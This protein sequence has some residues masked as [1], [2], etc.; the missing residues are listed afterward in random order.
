M[1]R[2][3]ESQDD[4]DCFEESRIAGKDQS[5]QFIKAK[6]SNPNAFLSFSE[7]MPSVDKFELVENSSATTSKAEPAPTMKVD[8]TAL[9]VTLPGDTPAKE[10]IGGSFQSFSEGMPSID[11]FA[12]TGFR[13]DELC[14]SITE[15]LTSSNFPLADKFDQTDP[16]KLAEC[17]GLRTI[18][19]VI[20]R[21]FSVP[22]FDQ[23]KIR[24]GRR[25]LEREYCFETNI[26]SIDTTHGSLQQILDFVHQ[27]YHST[28]TLLTCL[29]EDKALSQDEYV[30]L[31]LWSEVAALVTEVNAAR[32]L[33]DAA[34]PD[35]MFS[36]QVLVDCRDP[37]GELIAIDVEE[38][39]QQLGLRK[40]HQYLFGEFIRG[41][42]SSLVQ[43]LYEMY[44]RYISS[45]SETRVSAEELIKVCLA[46]GLDPESI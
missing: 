23:I 2:D 10:L 43:R 29:Y 41:T 4:E 39:V 44:R 5:K 36:K 9:P 18:G 30:D 6:K 12:I 16:Q 13:E 33:Y 1:T 25:L 35:P 42:Q 38:F 22:W 8:T 28:N 15:Y 24:L 31:Y 7:G 17:P 34:G 27:G 3:E 11:K 21:M 45:F 40:L 32:D 26:I 20:A 19:L 14:L 46:T 37:D